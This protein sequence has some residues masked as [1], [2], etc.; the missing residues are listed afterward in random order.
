MNEDFYKNLKSIG[1]FSNISEAS[2]YKDL[3]NNW[4][5][6]L[7]DV[8]GSTK[9]IKDGKYKEV[10][11]VGALCVISVLNI[12]EKLDLPF[13]FGGDGAFLLIPKSL[14]F[15]AKQAFLNVQKIAKDSYSLDLRIALV[16]ISKIYED[17]KKIQIAKY[18]VSKDYF[19]A[20]I[21][22]GGLEY[23][24]LLLKKDE[25]FHINEELDKSFKVD[26]SGLECRWEP[27]KTP[28]DEN[29]TILIKAFNE[30]DYKY[31]LDKLD[32]ILGSNISRNPILNENLLLSFEDENLDREA[33]LIS[34]NP[35]KRFFVR[36]GLKFIN[37]LGNI[38]MNSKIQTW[39]KYKNRVVS[40]TDTEKFDDMLRMVV[41]TTYKQSMLLEDYLKE[42]EKKKK[43]VYGLHK[44]DSSLM[45]CLIFERHGKHIHFVDGSNG[46]YA[47]AA[48]NLKGKI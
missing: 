48:K 43:L 31:I 41:A 22:G 44:S 18:E 19:Q 10:N 20:F 9:A 46:G 40:T 21:K 35:L 1:D 16:P 30:S 14:I 6:L 26:I 13:I 12:D 45:T 29:I 11:M 24:D 28:K 42:Q 37:L 8:K 47:I 17:N 15:K 5:V 34:L 7:S 2:I 36:Q 25:T 33:L 27:V 32:E 3:P 4:Y 39:S 23:T 38:L